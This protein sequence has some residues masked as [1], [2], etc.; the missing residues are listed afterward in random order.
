M[1]SFI[2][3]IKQWYKH[4]KLIKQSVLIPITSYD[5]YAALVKEA[6]DNSKNKV[7]SNCY[8]LP[9]EIKR[10]IHL[11]KFYQVKTEQ[12]LAFADDEGDYYYLFLYVNMSVSFTF[13]SL[14]KDILIENVY[15]EGR[16][17]KKQEIFES[18]LLDSGCEFLNTYRSI[19]DRPSL[20]PDKF[21]K[22]LE[23]L[24][25]TLAL[26]GKKIAIPSYK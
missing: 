19:E 22:K 2:H 23:V 4:Q 6:K 5:Q 25:K 7:F 16:K 10:L 1:F 17:N 12:G 3:K 11:K 15:Y 18:F 20:S 13:P 14:E 9:A 21:F 8:M 24:E 26:E